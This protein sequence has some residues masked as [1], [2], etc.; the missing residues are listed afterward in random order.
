MSK[1]TRITVSAEIDARTHDLLRQVTMATGRSEAEFVAEAVQR[2]AESDADYLAFIQ[3][4]VDSADRGELIP[5]AQ[6]M[7]ELDAMIAK[8]RARCST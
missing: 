6:V 1:L 8:Q 5:H 7:A 3:K 4:G 2:A